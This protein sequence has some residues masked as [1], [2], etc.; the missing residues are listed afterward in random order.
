M[1]ISQYVL[2][3]WRMFMSFP[4]VISFLGIYPMELIRD[5]HKNLLTKIF[6]AALFIIAKDWKQHIYYWIERFMLIA[7]YP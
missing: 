1:E 7:V 6:I 5:T 2:R 4:S 3:A